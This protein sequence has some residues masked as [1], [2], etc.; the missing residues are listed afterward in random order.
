[1]ALEALWAGWR[2][3]Y[4][5]AATAAERSGASGDCVFCALAASGPPRPETLVV[6]RGEHTL[7]ALNLYPYA[8]GHLLVLPV[9]HEAHLRGLDGAETAEIWPHWGRSL[10][11]SRRTA[12]TG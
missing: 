12:R 11:S 4:V 5:A 2:G 7:A 9:R 3:D 6:W 10:P 1:V 8:T